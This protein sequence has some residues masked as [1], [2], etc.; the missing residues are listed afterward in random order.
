M[1]SIYSLIMAFFLLSTTSYAKYVTPGTGETISLDYLVTN[2]AGAVTLSA[3][4]Y[5]VND[6]IVISLNDV[7]AITTNATVKFAAKTYFHI[8]G[9]LVID[10]P[11]NVLFTA[12][13]ISTGYLGV[14]LDGSAPSTIKNLTFEYGTAFKISD[15]SPIID[16][17]LFQYNN[18]NSS[19][20]FGSSSIVLFRSNAIIT[21]SKFLNNQRGAISGGANVSN[22]PQII[23]NYFE[24]NN[25]KNSNVP[26]L[27][28]GAT[29]P[30]TAR[31][32]NN[33]I[34]RSSTKSGG[35]GYLPIGD[36][37]II[38]TGN[39]IINNRYGINLQGGSTINAM[40]SY[41][42][43]DSNNTDNNPNTGGSGIA[44]SGGTADSHQNS[45]V[46]GNIFTA[47]LWGITIQNGS[48]PNLGNLNNA[49]TS[50]DGKNHFI[51]NTNSSVPGIDVYNN[52]PYPIS[53][54]NN[55]WNTND[56]IEIENKIY[57]FTDN[58][59]LGLVDYS[60]AV[61]PVELLN[62]NAT[63][64]NRNQVF[65]QWQTASE[66][67]TSHFVIERSSNG[68][69]FQAIDQQ[70]AAGNSS[71]ILNYEYTD[72]HVSGILFYRL[73]M[74]DSDGKYKYSPVVKV[75][76][77]NA[78]SMSITKVFPTV[79]TGNQKVNFI[80]ESDKI[81]K[82]NIQVLSAD[83]RVLQNTQQLLK[84]GS[85]GN[86]IQIQDGIGKGVIYLRFSAD[87]FQE[88][89]PLVKQ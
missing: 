88:T 44:F 68:Q 3:G 58:M 42:R 60:N 51:N 83:G 55:N 17:C 69:S 84:V 49:D 5:L 75:S 72:Q 30:D 77:V 9:A 29:G 48:M 13:D 20:S 11:D 41:N 50:D 54:Q 82:V 4:E 34:M 21:N 8:L 40:V 7:L 31:I 61:V 22:A 26:Q 64:T 33:K 43:I 53:A 62:F 28:F 36:A 24:G 25:T 39:L 78:A 70:W 71:S 74:V 57:H 16:S 89:I 27:N 52:S 37:H 80:L 19:T 67:N 6:T 2:S 23:G 45:I 10:A 38:I 15:C 87:E 56:L 35:I 81:R 59:T 47:N 86:F 65:L 76:V 14:H 73:K 63:I 32:I 1:K 18:N 66:S 85:N 46:T 79:I 12:Q